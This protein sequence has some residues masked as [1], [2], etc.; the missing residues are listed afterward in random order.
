MVWVM[1]RGAPELGTHT[2][3]GVLPTFTPLDLHPQGHTSSV[4]CVRPM[5][6]G[7]RVA[8]GS[9]DCTL[10]IWE[11]STGRCTREVAHRDGEVGGA[12]GIGG[13]RNGEDKGD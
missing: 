2:L 6:D 1:Q 11:L 12:G 13:T 3:Y 8:S 7:Q 10:R 4:L 5:S 9:S